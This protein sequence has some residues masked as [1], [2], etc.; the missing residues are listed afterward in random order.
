M[1]LIL[2]ASHKIHGRGPQY[3]CTLCEAT[4]TVDEKPQYE[5]HVVGHSQ[6]ELAKH[7]PALQA[8]GIF[9]TAGGDE[10]W[11]KWVDEHRVSDPHGWERW[12]KT[13]DG[14]SGGGL[15]DG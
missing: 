1:G 6:E 9:G 4:F 7:S 2:P 3:A 8:P 5:R 13:D 12:A 11:G 15:G 10:E 14:K